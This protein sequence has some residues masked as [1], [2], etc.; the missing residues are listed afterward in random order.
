MRTY[1]ALI[2]LALA[3]LPIQGAELLTTNP[4]PLA[5]DSRGGVMPAAEAFALSTIVEADGDI[6][7]SWEMPPGFYLYRKSLKLEHAGVDLLPRLEL[8]EAAHVTDE[9]FGE[10]E[11][12]FERLLARLPAGA[13]NAAPGTNVEL[14]LSYQGCLEDTYCYPPQQQLVSITLP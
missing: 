4:N 8:P 5:A 12:Y 13:L 9:F 1:S 3:A 6:V 7:L 11:V 14:Q 2:A 10:S